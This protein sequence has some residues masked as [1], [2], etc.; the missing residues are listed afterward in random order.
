MGRFQR[1]SNSI[2]LAPGDCPK[3][4]VRP[5]S[6]R[7][8]VGH[9]DRFRSGSFPAEQ[10]FGLSARLDM[11]GL[12]ACTCFFSRTVSMSHLTQSSLLARATQA[13]QSDRSKSLPTIGRWQPLRL[14]G[15]GGM[16]KVYLAHPDSAG[17]EAARYALKVLSED[18]EQD[19]RAVTQMRREAQVG[20]SISHPHLVSVLDWGVQQSPY[21]VVMP[22][23]RGTTLADLLSRD[24]LPSLPMAL[25]MTRQVGEALMALHQANWQ[26]SDIK[27]ANIFLSPDG[28]VTLLDLGLARRAD[29]SCHVSSRAIVGTLDYM[30]PEMLTS[31]LAADYRSDIYSLGVTLYQTL[32]GRLPYTA[33]S[34]GELAQLQHDSA[35]P[36]LRR[37]VPDLPV[38]VS[39]LVHDM[40]A[41]DPLRRPQSATELV[42]RL[43]PLEIATFAERVPA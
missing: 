22:Y 23:L 30:P 1:T 19:E 24:Q 2:E 39:E 6:S 17:P 34:L 35:P 3:L 14:I 21:Y 28:H 13:A 5:F 16:S 27:P 37:F 26:H 18:W 4:M 10:P 15:T 32:F 31:T 38:A 9:E 7:G 29:E 33:K 42:Q 25:W 20:N 11:A 41:H 8:R 12:T 40:L 36:R 43:I